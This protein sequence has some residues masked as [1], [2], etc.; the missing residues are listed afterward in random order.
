M[1]GMKHQRGEGGFTLIETILGMTVMIIMIVAVTN[2]FVS[3]LRTVTVGKAKAIGLSLANEQLEYLRDLPYQS[4]ATQG[5][6]IYPPGIIPDTQTLVRGGYTFTVKT[7][8]NYIDDP[9][10][11]YISCPCSTGPAAGKSKDLNPAD[12][13]KAQITVK[14]KSS[15][16]VV[17][18]LTSDFAAKAAETASNTGVLSVLVKDATDTPIANA[19]VTITNSA[20]TPNV[21]IST[22]T[23]NLGYVTIPNLP[24]DSSNRYFVT[25]SLGGY[26][27]DATE[28][29]PAG[30]SVTAVE[31]NPNILVQQV[32]QVVMQIDR[33]SNMTVHVVDTTGAAL[34]SKAIRITGA[35]VLEKT[36]GVASK[37][38]YDVTSTTNASGDITLTGIE[39]DAYSFTPPSG[40]YLVSA[41]PYVP[42]SLLPSSSQAVT[43]VLSTSS[44]YPT[45]TKMTPTSAQTGTSAVSFTLNGTNLGSGT[46]VA[47]RQAGQSDIVA[48]GLAFTGSTKITGSF[49]L[50]SAATGSWDLIVT[51]SGN[52]VTQTGGFNVTP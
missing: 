4:V 48:T 3:N 15:G 45:V 33:V 26:S 19:N 46:T 34:S 31:L 40:S 32:T 35:K 2:L 11:G 8:V 37:Y 18:T 10:D 6:A 25:A 49:N 20:Q 30:A 47:L 28:G 22:T 7:E 42:V 50:T 21:N 12:Y 27:T 24:L 16:A 14:L 41:Q 17:A 38:K 1:P 13:K 36:S 23:D 29:D 51:K 44:S 5:G 9:Y 52:T 43:L 39:W